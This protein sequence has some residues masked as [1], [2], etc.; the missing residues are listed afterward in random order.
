MPVAKVLLIVAL[1]APALVQSC[2]ATGP[3]KPLP[4][5]PSVD[6]LWTDFCHYVVIASPDL[7]AAYGER[8]LT[9]ASPR[10]LGALLAGDDETTRRAIR[11]LDDTNLAANHPDLGAVWK[12]MRQRARPSRA[13]DG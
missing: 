10:Q 13:G 7:A 11:L 4:A 9:E 6:Q 12:S 8:L 2:A 5:A 1:L 3:T